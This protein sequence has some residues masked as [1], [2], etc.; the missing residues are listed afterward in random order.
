MKHRYSVTLTVLACC[1]MPAA[2]AAD[3][4]S[5]SYWE[6]AYLN[7]TRETTSG[8]TTA[9]DD[10]EGFRAA[11]SVGLAR[12]V[13]AVVDFD[14]RR[15]INS[16]DAFGALGLGVHTT[17]PVYQFFGNVTWE[18]LEFDS[19][20]NPSTDFDDE[21]YGVEVGARYALRHVELHAAYKYID[22]GEV[23]G[24][25]TTAARYG[26]GVALSLSPWWALAADYR[27][28]QQEYE[29]S[30]TSAEDEY[31]EWSVGFRR[32]FPTD[33]DPRKRKD[34]LLFPDDGQQ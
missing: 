19:N 20:T 33:S 17:N 4:L 1:A 26:A 15:Y 29:A 3:P 21:G 8:G 34:G 25:D 18:R 13:N 14:Q 24:A 27:I 5:S 12:N 7:S 2:H 30:G 11:I 22:L 16:R 9:E 6:A 31:A 23:R 28:R 10:V 32:Y